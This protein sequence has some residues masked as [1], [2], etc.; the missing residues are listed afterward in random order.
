MR[1][2]KDAKQLFAST[3]LCNKSKNTNT[4]ETKSK[5]GTLNNKEESQVTPEQFNT[6]QANIDKMFSLEV[7][8]W[9]LRIKSHVALKGA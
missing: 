2:E 3:H 5:K 9:S 6:T 4:H 8:V 1:K 7:P